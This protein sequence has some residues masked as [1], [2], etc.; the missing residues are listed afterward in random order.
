MPESTRE[1]S[2]LSGGENNTTERIVIIGPRQL[3]LAVLYEIIVQEWPMAPNRGT[4]NVRKTTIGTIEWQACWRT[5]AGRI[6]NGKG[7]RA[8]RGDMV[9]QVKQGN[10]ALLHVFPKSVC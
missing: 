8:G 5:I 2:K 7:G 9:P 1:V 3:V 10:Q 4:H 6:R